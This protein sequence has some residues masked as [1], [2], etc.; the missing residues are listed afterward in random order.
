MNRRKPKGSAAK[1]AVEISVIAVVALLMIASAV[2]LFFKPWLDDEVPW[3]DPP[4]ETTVTP[5]TVDTSD[6][7]DNDKYVR[8]QN[9]TNFLVLGRD[10]VANLT[11]AIML[12]QF[13][14]K[15]HSVNIMQIPRDTYAY[16]E[17]TYHKING[18]YSH[19]MVQNNYNVKK[20]MENVVEY[21]QNNFNVK[22]DYY[23]LMNLDAF[24]Q[25][26][27][28]MGGVEIDVPEDMYYEDEYQNLYIDI[29]KGKQVLDG[30][31][32]EQFV[33]FRSG[34]ASADAGRV[35]AQKLFLAAFAS[36]FKEKITVGKI[37][38]IVNQVFKNLTTNMSITDI[39]YY[40]KEALS[41]VFT[42][43]TFVSVPYGDARENVDSG[44]WYVVL[45]RAATL[46]A[47]NEYF[48]VYNKAIDDSIFDA[49][50]VLTN[51]DK[52]HINSFYISTGYTVSVTYMDDVI[53]TGIDIPTKN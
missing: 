28:L 45:N 22:I 39:V 8:D 9:V 5:G 46:E 53:S 13:N 33:R 7:P 21:I 10:R 24:V 31:H 32:A 41:L 38:D 2:A 26:V 34:W 15:E 20:S 50:R 25:I 17:S 37:D 16:H 51:K 23:V 44:Q 29:K 3:T 48:N 30:E 47:I 1:L 19:Y 40:A 27:D 18:L 12:V 36:Q 14:T 6:P 52:E 4:N 35:D 43:T 49:S 11:D 42:K